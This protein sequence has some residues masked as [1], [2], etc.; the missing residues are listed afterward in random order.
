MTERPPDRNGRGL[1]PYREIDVSADPGRPDFTIEGAP[2]A[3]L[4]IISGPS[5]VG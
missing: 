4:A 2:G 5:G 1:D 3:I